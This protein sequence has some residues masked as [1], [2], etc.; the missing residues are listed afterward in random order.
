MARSS[1]ERKAMFA[2]LS[3]LNNN[4]KTKLAILA[5]TKPEFRPD[6]TFNVG[7]LPRFDAKLLKQMKEGGLEKKVPF[8]KE[9]LGIQSLNSGQVRVNF[10]ENHDTTSK[11]FSNFDQAEDF[12]NSLLK[13]GFKN[14]QDTR[15]R[16]SPEEFE[17]LKREGKLKGKVE[18]RR[19]IN[20][21]FPELSYVEV[22]LKDI[23]NIS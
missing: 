4:Q 8:D 17:K 1:A 9:I 23:G 12:R 10:I 18:V 22:E 20:K 3:E 2:R 7:V 21:E 19:K 11:T 15:T 16:F 6:L 14:N 5:G 13:K